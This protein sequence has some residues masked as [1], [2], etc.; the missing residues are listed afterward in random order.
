MMEPE[1]DFKPQLELMRTDAQ[2]DCGCPTDWD[3]HELF[4]GQNGKEKER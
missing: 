4:G 3:N 1:Q 2:G